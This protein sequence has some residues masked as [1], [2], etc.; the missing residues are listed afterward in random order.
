LTNDREKADT[1]R[2]E[3]KMREVQA[4]VRL[5][6]IDAAARREITEAET[7]VML[8]RLHAS[9]DQILLGLEIA[10]LEQEARNEAGNS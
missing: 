5:Q 3:T 9:Q 4:K 1:I 2:N 6:T 7:S 8:R 10:R